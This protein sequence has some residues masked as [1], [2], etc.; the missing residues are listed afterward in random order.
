MGNC[1]RERA[2]LK[3]KTVSIWSAVNS[4]KTDFTNPFYSPKELLRL[5]KIP[6]TAFFE[7]QVWKEL[8]FKHSPYYFDQK[9]AFNAAYP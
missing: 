9:H 4:R 1:E 7:L 5:G 6:T 8:Y 2:E 3:A